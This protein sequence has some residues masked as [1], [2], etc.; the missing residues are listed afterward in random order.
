MPFILASQLCVQKCIVLSVNEQNKFCQLIYGGSSFFALLPELQQIQTAFRVDY[1]LFKS[2]LRDQE[3][4][5]NNNAAVNKQAAELL[6][7]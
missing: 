7:I 6:D 4:H 3:S 2:M 5:R 1:F